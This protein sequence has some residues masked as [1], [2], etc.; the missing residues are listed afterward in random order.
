MPAWLLNASV[1]GVWHPGYRNA[2]SARYAEANR[3]ANTNADEN[4][5]PHGDTSDQNGRTA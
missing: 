2:C 1:R 5:H 3:N 4:S